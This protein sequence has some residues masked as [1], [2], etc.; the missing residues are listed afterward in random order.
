MKRTIT[1]TWGKYNG[2]IKDESVKSFD[3]VWTCDTS[4]DESYAAMLNRSTELMK[5]GYMPEKI[6]GVYDK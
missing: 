5:D 3:E 4:C 1:W 6:V 2:L